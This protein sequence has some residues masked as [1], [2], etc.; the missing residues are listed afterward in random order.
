MGSVGALSADEAADL[1]SALIAACVEV[2]ADA[3][4]I[5]SGTFIP[6]P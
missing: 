6:K 5:L 4:A 2:H 1:R 3:V